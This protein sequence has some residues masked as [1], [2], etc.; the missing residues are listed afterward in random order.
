MQKY[1]I[2]ARTHMHAHTLAAKPTVFYSSKW[3]TVLFPI[4]ASWSQNK[5]FLSLSDWTWLMPHTCAHTHTHT[6][7]YVQFVIYQVFFFIS[8]RTQTL[9]QTKIKLILFLQ[10]FLDA[11]ALTTVCFHK[12]NLTQI[13]WDRAKKSR[14]TCQDIHILNIYSTETVVWPELD[15]PSLMSLFTET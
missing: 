8:H 5:V 7:W 2:W 10:R 11:S 4:L 9:L 15:T 1:K 12:Q 14:K 6:V 13:Q 3:N